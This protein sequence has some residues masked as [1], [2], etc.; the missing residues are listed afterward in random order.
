MHPTISTKFIYCTARYVLSTGFLT[1]AHAKFYDPGL[2]H[3]PN[4]LDGGISR[5]G[6]SVRWPSSPLTG[7]N[8]LNM[9]IVFNDPSLWPVISYLRGISYFQDSW[10]ESCLLQSLM[11]FS[12]LH[13]S[14]QWYTIGVRT[15]L[16][17]IERITDRVLT[18]IQHW[19]LDKR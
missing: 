10:N 11:C 16:M 1:L 15:R 17:F 6:H 4:A 12:Q 5:H 3:I 14:L 7:I 9:T 18:Y 19:H 13:A 8:P 2:Q